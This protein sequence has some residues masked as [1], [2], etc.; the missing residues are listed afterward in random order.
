MF[1]VNNIIKG[2]KTAI[3]QNI[4]RKSISKRHILIFPKISNSPEV[5]FYK[6][7]RLYFKNTC[8]LVECARPEHE[9]LSG[10]E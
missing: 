6:Q 9:T 4:F 2:L 3:A 5:V 7:R 1:K 10:K 8:S